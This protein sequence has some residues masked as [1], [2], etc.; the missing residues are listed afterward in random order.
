MDEGLIPPTFMDFH[1]TEAR[2]AEELHNNNFVTACKEML[3]KHINGDPLYLKTKDIKNRHWEANKEMNSTGSEDWD[4]SAKEA[5]N[6]KQHKAYF[7]VVRDSTGYCWHTLSTS[8]G[9]CEQS[10]K[11]ERQWKLWLSVQEG[12]NQREMRVD[13][14]TNHEYQ[15]GRDYRHFEYVTNHPKIPKDVDDNSW[16]HHSAHFVLVERHKRESLDENDRDKLAPSHFMWPISNQ[17]DY[18]S[19]RHMGVKIEGDP[20]GLRCGTEAI[21]NLFE[22][23]TVSSGQ[24][25]SNCFFGII[26]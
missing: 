20:V 11:E 19:D 24:R 9:W 16:A 4:M 5:G 13:Y 10:W 7:P 6:T 23:L 14:I 17:T 26:F 1:Y 18:Q 12:A 2:T 22:N 25:N 8:W 21:Y 15:S 3:K